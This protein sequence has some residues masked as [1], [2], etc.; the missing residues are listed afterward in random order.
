MYKQVPGLRCVR[1]SQAGPL[2]FKHSDVMAAITTNEVIVFQSEWGQY[3]VPFGL[4]NT[5]TPHCVTTGHSM[6]VCTVLYC[7]EQYFLPSHCI[8]IASKRIEYL[9][10]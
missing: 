2:L 8:Q 3:N 4:K 7:I 5:L 10:R 9:K 6:Y 1:I